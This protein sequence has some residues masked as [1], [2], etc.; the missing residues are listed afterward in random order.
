VDKDLLSIQ[1]AR[2]LSE[3]AYKAQLIW[4]HAAQEDVDRV[5]SAMAE[6]AYLAS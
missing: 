6:A 3:A 1:E 2:N 5:C 4:G